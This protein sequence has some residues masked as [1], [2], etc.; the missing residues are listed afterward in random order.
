MHQTLIPFLL[1]A[2]STTFTPGPNNIMVMASG[3]N[4]GLRRTV[5]HM[6]GIAVGFAVMVV[7]VGL[8]LGGLF[9]RFPV[10]HE[11]LKWLGGVYLL[12]LSWKIASAAG[13]G[14]ADRRGRPLRFIEAAAFQWVNPKAWMMAISAFAVYSIADPSTA[15]AEALTFAAIFGVIC[16]PS[17]GA[18]ALFGSALRRL[19]GNARSLRLFNG[20]LGLLLAAS[21][22]LLFV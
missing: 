14:S 10:L 1:F 8:G 11:A 15:I 6:F 22:L 13:L 9:A 3:A 16:V 21:V 20:A 7:A 18:W 2:L 12:W 4:F 17:T 19:L 5:P